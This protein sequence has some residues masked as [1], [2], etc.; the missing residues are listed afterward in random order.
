M[1]SEC[2]VT[3]PPKEPRGLLQNRR[4]RKAKASPL[5]EPKPE[6]KP[7]KKKAERERERREQIRERER[8]RDQRLARD[9]K[10]KSTQAQHT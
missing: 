10:T 1:S 8:E 7:E 6:A 9:G 3:P 5:T 2:A 4:V